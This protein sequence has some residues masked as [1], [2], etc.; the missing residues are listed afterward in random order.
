MSM[1]YIQE[2]WLLMVGGV[3]LDCSRQTGVVAISLVAGTTQ[4]YRL[5][6]RIRNEY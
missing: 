3:Q 2:K 1:R 4:E 6:V 5:Q